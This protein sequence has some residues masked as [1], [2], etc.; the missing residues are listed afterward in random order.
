MRELKKTGG[1]KKILLVEDDRFI[2]DMYK[3]KMGKEN[4]EV[5]CAE[6][7]ASAIKIAKE[8]MPDIILLDVVMPLMDGFETLQAMKQDDKLKNIPIVLL[9]NLGQR[10]S[11]E[12]GL[13]IGAA[14]YII[15]A[16]FSPSE[17][18][19]K[20]KNIIEKNN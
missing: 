20:I 13:K 17:V 10:R 15:K 8:I 12:K 4:F 9:T 19:D 3:E 6:D 7:G 1:L 16:H 14:D 18:V 2:L 11:V 5:R